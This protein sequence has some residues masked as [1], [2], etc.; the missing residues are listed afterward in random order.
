MKLYVA[1]THRDN[2]SPQGAQSA[3]HDF[4]LT[5]IEKPTSCDV[6]FKLLRSAVNYWYLDVITRLFS[7]RPLCQARAS[8][9]ARGEAEGRYRPRAW[10]RANV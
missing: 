10:Y 4:V 7:Y 6:C 9:S 1:V 8:I 2:V 3:L 5:C